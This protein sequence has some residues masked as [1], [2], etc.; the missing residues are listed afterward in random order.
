MSSVMP[1]NRLEE[2]KT[3]AN[4]SINNMNNIVSRGQ[5][6]SLWHSNDIKTTSKQ[7]YV[8]GFGT[9]IIILQLPI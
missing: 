1:T 8:D 3:A 5:K 7:V 9:I 4:S 6:Q 2:F